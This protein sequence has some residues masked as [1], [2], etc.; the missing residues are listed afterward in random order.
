MP[1]RFLFVAAAAAILI[2]NHGAKNAVA[3]FVDVT[4]LAGTFDFVF[5][6]DPSAPGQITIT[7]SNVLLT[8]INGA[9]ILPIASTFSPEFLTVTA[10]YS[11]SNRTNYRLSES[12]PMVQLFGTGAGVIETAEV[13]AS[14]NHG[15]NTPGGF[16]TPSTLNLTG[17]VAVS[18]AAYLLILAGSPQGYNFSSLQSSIALTY[19]DTQSF[20]YV[21]EYGGTITWP[22]TFTEGA[23][24]E[25]TS[26]VLL[27]IG[28]TAFCAFRFLGQKAYFRCMIGPE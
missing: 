1:K 19:T 14:I 3:G 22:G 20:A 9:V 5:S 7:Y 16:G 28:V 23:V 25:P 2:W 21:I 12:G 27:G 10:T 11:H 18:P 13:D 6:V 24:P 17:P 26:I 4:Q 15:S 8:E